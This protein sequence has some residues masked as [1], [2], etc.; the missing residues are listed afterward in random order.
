MKETPPP[1]PTILLPT[2]TKSSWLPDDARPLRILAE[3][4]EPMHRFARQGVSGTIVF[5]GLRPARPQGATWPL[6]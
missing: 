4:L 1:R 6:L 2:R 5:F 3:Y